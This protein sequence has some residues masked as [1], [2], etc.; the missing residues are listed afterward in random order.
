L[1]IQVHYF[2]ITAYIYDGGSVMKVV[3]LIGAL[4]NLPPDLD[5]TLALGFGRHFV[6]VGVGDVGLGYRHRKSRI[7]TCR[8]FEGSEEVAVV[9]VG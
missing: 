2:S 6:A 1:C 9:E 8:G 3:E 7:V 5:V 4:Q